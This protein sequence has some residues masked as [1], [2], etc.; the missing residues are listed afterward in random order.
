V[1][2][3]IYDKTQA[4][5]VVLG[6][7]AQK[8]LESRSTL[9]RC[10]SDHE[11]GTGWAQGTTG[12]MAADW[13]RVDGRTSMARSEHVAQ[14]EWHGVFGQ[15]MGHGYSWITRGMQGSNADY[16][17]QWDI[18]STVGVHWC[19]GRRLCRGA[20]PPQRMEHALPGVLDETR[21]WKPHRKPNFSQIIQ[22]RPLQQRVLP[23]F[24]GAELPGIG[25][26]SP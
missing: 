5:T 9:R 2:D 7:A 1:G 11:P 17:D 6:E 13:R 10:H 15:E 14:D 20:A 22:L 18:M 8:M 16:Q 4:Q 19:I 23:G 21:I 26:D 24:L 25:T 3:P 12:W